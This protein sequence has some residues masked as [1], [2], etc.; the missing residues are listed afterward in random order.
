MIGKGVLEGS[1]HGLIEI[2]YWHVL[3]EPAE[4]HLKTQN[5][6]GF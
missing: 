3:E 2:L 1:G 5:Y 4:K 6:C